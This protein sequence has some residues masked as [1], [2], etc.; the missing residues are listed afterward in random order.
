[1]PWALHSLVSPVQREQAVDEQQGAASQGRRRAV[2]GRRRGCDLGGV[3]RRK[4]GEVGAQVGDGREEGDADVSGDG[5]LVEGRLEQGRRGG[6]LEGAR[7]RRVV[8]GVRRCPLGVDV[9]LEAGEEVGAG[10]ADE[11]G[12]GVGLVGDDV[13][14]EL[15]GGCWRLDDG[16][17][18]ARLVVMQLW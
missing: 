10:A 11:E 1:M 2:G 4:G 5:D 7:R 18:H 16:G 3:V 14:E 6:G 15:G 12:R 17:E 13:V 9:L 8:D